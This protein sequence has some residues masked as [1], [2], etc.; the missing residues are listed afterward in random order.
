MISEALARRYYPDD[1][2]N[3]TRLFYSWIGEELHPHTRALNIGAGP[4]TKSAARNMKSRVQT[5]V[6]I[7]IDPVVLEN[8][9]LHEAYLIEN[10]RFPLADASFDCAYAD[11]VFEHVDR[12]EIFLREIHRVLK[13]GGS[14]FFRTPNLGHYVAMGSRLTPFW[15][16]R[17]LANRMRGLPTDTHEPWPTRYRLNTRSAVSR[18]A[19]EAG[20]S[21]SE[22]R[23]IEPDPSYL[24]FNGLAFRMGVAY[25]R[26]VNSTELL[27]PLRANILGKLTK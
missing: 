9:E 7:D 14:I 22:F 15:I 16:H 4:E 1:R 6:G 5:L 10:D 12:P 25:E 26:L 27:A 13:P 17:H 23:M 3:G 2:K 8:G 21:K 18:L 19:R 24:K 11:M 20:F